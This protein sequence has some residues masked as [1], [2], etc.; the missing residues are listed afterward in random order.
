VTY[1]PHVFVMVGLCI[2]LRRVIAEEAGLV[3]APSTVNKI[4]VR[5][6]RA[7]AEPE[8]PAT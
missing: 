7:Q 6:M 8:V 2:A 1:Y 5:R 3:N 4:K